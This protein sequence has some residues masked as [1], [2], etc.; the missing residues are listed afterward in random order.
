M[1]ATRHYDTNHAPWPLDNPNDVSS[2][3]PGS[4]RMSDHYT[5]SFSTQPEWHG[6]YTYSQNSEEVSFAHTFDRNGHGLPQLRDLTSS[7]NDKESQNLA[8]VKGEEEKSSHG[9]HVNRDPGQSTPRDMPTGLGHQPQQY[10]ESVDSESLR[11]TI[12]N[13]GR[14]GTVNVSRDSSE[15]ELQFRNQGGSLPTSDERFPVL[16]EEDEDAIDE[17]EVLD[18]EGDQPQHPQ[19][20]AERTAA[21]RKMKRFR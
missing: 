19:T 10:R 6:G 13:T 12:N 1:L 20:A 3:R 15:S 14:A 2:R 4:P 9:R 5:S 17:D 8:R 7:S 21:R 18:G 11:D 16:K